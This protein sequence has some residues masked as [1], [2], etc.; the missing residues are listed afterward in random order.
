MQ[1][2]RMI[3]ITTGTSRKATVWNGQEI[4][5]SDFIQSLGRPVRTQE[6]PPGI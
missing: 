5:W 6:S 4:Y 1:F 3:K 2:D